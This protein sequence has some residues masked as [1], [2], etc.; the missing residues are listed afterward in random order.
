[1][2]RCSY[3]ELRAAR[4]RLRP[5]QLPGVLAADQRRTVVLRERRRIVRVSTDD[6]CAH[7]V[8]HRSQSAAVQRVRVVTARRRADGPL[9]ERWA[10]A[11]GV[12]AREVVFGPSTSANTYVLAHAFADVLEAGNEVIVTNQDHEANT[13]AI[14]RAAERLGCAV[15]EWTTD[16]KTGLLDIDQFEALLSER[17]GVGDRATRIEHRRLRERRHVGSPSSPTP[18]ALA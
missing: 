5:L 18:S 7:R 1:V 16:P 12:Q 15:K 3:R 11:L 8:L 10:E 4:S 2:A 6:R 9:R 13:G 17:T 14:R